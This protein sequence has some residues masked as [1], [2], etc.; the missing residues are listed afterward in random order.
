MAITVIATPGASDA[1]AYCDVDYADAY[2][3]GNPYASTWTDA[4]TDAKGWALI[5]ATRI[6]DAHVTWLGTVSTTTQRLLW[7]RTGVFDKRGIAIEDDVI[8][9]AVKDATSECA[10]QLLAQNRTEDNDLARQGITSLKAGPVAFTFNGSASSQVIPDAAK[11]LIAHL[12][13]AGDQPFIAKL[14]RS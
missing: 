2:H 6:I 7:P 1:N 11:A 9:E 14:I 5:E 12:L 10:R 13:A 8:P 4:E 3:Q